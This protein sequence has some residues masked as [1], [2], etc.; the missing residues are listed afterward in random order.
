M[1]AQPRPCRGGR[2]TSRERGGIGIAAGGK[3]DQLKPKNG[4]NTATPA[5][6]RELLLCRQSPERA[7]RST[8]QFDPAQRCGVVTLF[9]YRERP[10]AGGGRCGT[11]STP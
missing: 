11:R 3:G 5:A 8:I 2:A 9:R 6:S 4:A 10:A 1:Y 7:F